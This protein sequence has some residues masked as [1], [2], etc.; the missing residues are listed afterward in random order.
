MK[1]TELR[2]VGRRGRERQ[3]NLARARDVVLE[4]SGGLCE[5]R[6]AS[7]CF[8]RGSMLHHRRRRS[9]GGSDDPA[10]LLWVCAICHS[11]IH[12]LPGLALERGW[13]ISGF[14]CEDPEGAWIRD[15]RDGA[16]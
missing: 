8:G 15:V 3:R 1:R 2:R 16:A 12:G 13:L 11:L 6:A 7:N 5:A 9:Q 14:A 10:N 4:R